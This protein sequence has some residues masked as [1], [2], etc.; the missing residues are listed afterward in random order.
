[1][2]LWT[3]Y[4]LGYLM[5]QY[6]HVKYVIFYGLGIAVAQMDRIDTP[7]LPKCIARIHWYSD[8]WKYFDRGLYEFLHL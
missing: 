7:A 4:S 6:F 1:M 5:G 8:M 2:N 3:L